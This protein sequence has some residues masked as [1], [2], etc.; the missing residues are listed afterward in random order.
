MILGLLAY[1]GYQYSPIPECLG[2]AKVLDEV[3]DNTMLTVRWSFADKAACV[4][5]TEQQ[6]QTW[7]T[8]AEVF[9]YAGASWCSR[10]TT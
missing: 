3:S 5:A 8:N 2:I 9:R 7:M 4:V 1:A 6:R 10:G